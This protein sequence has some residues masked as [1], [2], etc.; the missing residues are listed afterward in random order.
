[1]GRRRAILSPYLTTAQLDHLADWCAEVEGNGTDDPTM[2]VRCVT[3]RALIRQ[4]RMGLGLAV[5]AA[6]P[7]DVRAKAA[8]KASRARWDRV[9]A[10]KR[11]V[12]ADPATSHDTAD[13]NA[14]VGVAKAGPKLGT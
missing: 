2:T 10:R 8:Q 9:A 5:N 6:K 4:A 12:S 14:R 7:F 3:M 11:A 1:M 13:E